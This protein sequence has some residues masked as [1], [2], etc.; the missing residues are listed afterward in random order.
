MKNFR[1]LNKINNKGQVEVSFNWIY[2]LIA[3]AVILLF[4]VGIVAKQKIVSEDSLGQEVLRTM[5]TIFTGAEVSEK[6]KNLI[7][8]EGLIDY[9]F[10]FR[11]ENG[12][13]EYGLQGRGQKIDLP[14]TPLFSP[15]EVKTGQILTWS[16][17][18]KLPFKVI[19]LLIVSSI[20][21]KYYLLGEGNLA[22]TFMDSAAGFNLE[23]IDNINQPLDVGN[24]FQV[25][26]IDLSGNQIQEGEAVPPGFRNLDPDKV[27]AVV[28]FQEGDLQLVQ[29]YEK[30]K[31]ERWHK[32][33]SPVALL[34]FNGEKDALLTAALFAADGMQLQ[35]NLQKILRRLSY[36]QEIYQYK[37]EELER[38][39]LGLNLD[40]RNAF[41]ALKNSW[42]IYRVDSV[43][44]QTYLANILTARISNPCP[45]LL[46]SARNLQRDNKNLQQAGNCVA[47][48]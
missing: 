20:N 16:L 15:R 7:N 17:P 5:G 27:S 26:V 11:C 18:Y 1:K 40:C 21:T 13:G 45:T 6:T 29:Y 38:Y 44:C 41:N 43:S 46:F 39:S 34:A 31:E 42:D 23:K 9:T 28:F 10:Y 8:T 12:L 37:L 33:G 14:I 19:D 35:C 2:V 32:L 47:L 30:D 24:N 22:R 48:Y 36:L 4:F 25:R 3:G